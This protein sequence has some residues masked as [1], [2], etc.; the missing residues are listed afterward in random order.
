MWKDAV[1]D[2]KKTEGRTKPERKDRKQLEQD[3]A[4][5]SFPGMDSRLL[6]Q[7]GGRGELRGEEEYT[8][9]RRSHER[10]KIQRQLT[11]GK[12][13][14]ISVFLDCV[15]LTQAAAEGEE[16]RI[17]KLDAAPGPGPELVGAAAV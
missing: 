13:S 12:L 1:P 15:R 16:V 11:T 10:D 7:S 6:D 17:P 5:P 2:H 9:F 3:Q 8:G 14:P 4:G